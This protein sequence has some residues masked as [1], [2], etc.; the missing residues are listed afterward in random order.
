MASQPE[1][2]Y[3]RTSRYRY[4]GS[5][6]MMRD[7]LRFVSDDDRQCYRKGVRTLAL[8]YGGILVLVVAITALR[9]ELQEATAKTMAGAV[10][11][12]DPAHPFSVDLGRERARTRQ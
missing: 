10:S 8:V 11:A 4:C 12:A 9:G 7:S 3:A 2:H 5:S 1:V 6:A